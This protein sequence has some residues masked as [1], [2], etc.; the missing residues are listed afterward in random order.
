MALAKKDAERRVR[1][2]EKK[3]DELLHDHNNDGVNRRQAMQKVEGSV[4]FHTAASTAFPNHSRAR[5][6][7]RGR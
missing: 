6:T 1:M 5:P 3:K 7:R 4:T 2:S